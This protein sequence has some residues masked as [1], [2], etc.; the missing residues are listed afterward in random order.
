MVVTS[1]QKSEEAISPS[2]STPNL[3]FPTHLP[4]L[5]APPSLKIPR[6]GGFDDKLSNPFGL[7]LPFTNLPNVP[8][9]KPMSPKQEPQSDDEKIPSD[10]GKLLICPLKKAFLKK[11]ELER[12]SEHWCPLQFVSFCAYIPC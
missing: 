1:N 11:Q 4:G 5:T 3:T 2:L 8:Y 9:L 12:V 10:S 7:S 6:F